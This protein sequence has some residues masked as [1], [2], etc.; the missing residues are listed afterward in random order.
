MSRPWGWERLRPGEGATGDERVGWHH[1]LDGREFEQALGGGGGQGRLKCCS[2]AVTKGWVW[3]GDW[4]TM[5]DSLVFTAGWEAVVRLLLASGERSPGKL[6]STL[7]RAGRTPP[8]GTAWLKAWAARRLQTL[9]CA[10]LRCGLQA[11][12]YV[13][14][15]FTGTSQG[16]C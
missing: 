1:W 4:T 13:T 7:Q 15:K 12:P 14:E 6:L 16:R 8:Q 2:P 9:A 3:L 11:T 10:T 5:R